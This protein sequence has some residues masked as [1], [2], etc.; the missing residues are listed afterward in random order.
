LAAEHGLPLREHSLVR[1]FSKFY[2][3]WSGKTHLEQ[4]SVENLARMLEAEIKED[5]TEM[6][7]HPGYIDPDYR[8]SYSVEREV[9]LRTLCDPRIRH[10]LEAQAIRLVSY[11]DL[12]GGRGGRG[13]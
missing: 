7:C 2:G 8:G 1:Y 4:I 10:T 9:E 12:P 6:S 11:H 13:V 5:I 3:Q